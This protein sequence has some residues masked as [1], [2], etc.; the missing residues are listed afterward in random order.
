MRVES[1]SLWSD[2]PISSLSKNG[3]ACRWVEEFSR[4][5]KLLPILLLGFVSFC[6]SLKQLLLLQACHGRGHIWCFAAAVPT[7]SRVLMGVV[8]ALQISLLSKPFQ[9]F[10]QCLNASHTN[11]LSHCAY[12]LTAFPAC[13]PCSPGLQSGSIPG[14]SH[15]VVAS[16]QQQLVRM[17]SSICGII[18]SPLET[19]ASCYAS[20][21]WKPFKHHYF[22]FSSH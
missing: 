9:T 3:F 15:L 8:D 12:L 16:Q 2:E 1:R 22:C 4:T 7:E 14:P 20:D 6:G 10:L 21:P 19:L 18:L 5:P 11:L 17:P 13:M